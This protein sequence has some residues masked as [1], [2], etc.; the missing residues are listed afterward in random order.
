MGIS[1]FIHPYPVRMIP[2]IARRLIERHSKPNDTALDLFC[3]SG[4]VL[5]EGKILGRRSIGIDINPLAISIA[6][7]K[8]TPIDPS[9]LE[10]YLN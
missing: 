1:I 8:T 10:L 3:G 7:V 9:K 5:A 6:K 4:S 2:Q